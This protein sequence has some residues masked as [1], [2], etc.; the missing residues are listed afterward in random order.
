MIA[1]GVLHVVRRGAMGARSDEHDRTMAFADIAMGQIKA[2]RQ[3]ADPRNFEVWYH[4]ATVYNPSLNKTINEHLERKGHLDATDLDSIRDQFIA[5][6]RLNQEI[7]S[8]G[9]K[10][11]EEIDQVM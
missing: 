7:D 11:A 6:S 9:A 3:S 5:S 1:R 2:L 4:Y 8:L 10:V